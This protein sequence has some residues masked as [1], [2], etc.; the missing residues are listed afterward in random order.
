[1]NNLLVRSWTVSLLVLPSN[2]HERS[3]DHV[4][5]LVRY[6]V[7]L[8]LTITDVLNPRMQVRAR[9]LFD[10]THH[11]YLTLSKKGSMKSLSKS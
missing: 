10:A 1:M 3:K 9:S 5:V 4:H 6:T 7:P 8:A 2:G 11:G